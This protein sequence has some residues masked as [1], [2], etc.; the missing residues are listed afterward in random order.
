MRS[1]TFQKFKK[2]EISSQLSSEMDFNL[3]AFA[4]REKP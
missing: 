2:K 3:I 1:D 4:G